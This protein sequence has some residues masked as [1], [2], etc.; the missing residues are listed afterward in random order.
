MVIVLIVAI[1]VMMDRLSEEPVKH[2]AARTVVA[3]EVP[4]EGVGGV[5]SPE[6]PRR[7]NADE[8]SKAKVWDVNE[9]TSHFEDNEVTAESLFSPQ[10]FF[11]GMIE[12]IETNAL[13]GARVTVH[14]IAFRSSLMCDVD[15]EDVSG[16]ASLHRG[17]TAVFV[18]SGAR[19]FVGTVFLHHC[20]FVNPAS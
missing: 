13:S 10:T 15:V 6:A 7:G 14:A 12:S 3:H 20:K 17:Q 2:R 16:L 11:E 5:V 18:G 4:R 1:W 9:I 8:L 19:R